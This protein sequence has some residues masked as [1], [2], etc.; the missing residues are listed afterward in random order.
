MLGRHGNNLYWMSRYLER[1]ENNARRIQAVLHYAL[2][3]QDEGSDEWVAIIVNYGHEEFF[4]AKHRGYAMADVVNFLLRDPD[5]PDSVAS[6]MANARQNGK[7]VR[8]AL[9]REAWQSLNE[10]WIYCDSALKRPVM[11]RELPTILQ[12]I[13]KNSESF[14]GTVFGTMPRNDVF[15]FLRAGTFVERSDNTARMVGAK[16]HRLLPLAKVIGGSDDYSQWEIML[17]A[18]AAWSSFNTLKKGKVDP[19]DVAE[20]LMFD[21]KMPRSLNLCY[22]EIIFNLSA[23]CEDY[24][25]EYPSLKLAEEIYSTLGPGNGT[26]GI[27][28]KDFITGHIDSNNRLSV[29]ICSDFNFD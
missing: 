4:S 21:P 5:N 10:S 23:L 2:G 28:L 25:R 14:R 17:R 22:R 18:Q 9:S 1:S 26:G 16:Y 3:R 12:T 24:G 11:I 13:I 29:S 20:F 8:T 15:N 27:D 7:A 19:A 6:L